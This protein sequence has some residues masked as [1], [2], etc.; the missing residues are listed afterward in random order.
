MQSVAFAFFRVFPQLCRFTLM[1][2]YTVRLFYIPE[3]CKRG[4][5]L[6]VCRLLW[7]LGLPA[8]R[9]S[10]TRG[11]CIRAAWKIDVTVARAVKRNSILF[12]DFR[13]K[14]WKDFRRRF[15]R[16][17]FFKAIA[18]PVEAVVSSSLRHDTSALFS[19]FRAR[20]HFRRTAMLKEQLMVVQSGEGKPHRGIAV[21]LVLFVRVKFRNIPRVLTGGI[22]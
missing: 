15:S 7:K 12:S 6:C 14:F 20:N 2:L 10:L 13:G 9:A 3:V 11:N 18:S 19:L 5:R 1:T 22:I 8:M 4:V 21:E 17:I 16:R